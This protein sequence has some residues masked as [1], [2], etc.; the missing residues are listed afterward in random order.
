MRRRTWA[1]FIA[2]GF[3]VLGLVYGQMP[4]RQYPAIEYYDF[5]VP[6]DYAEKT[7]W[8]F[9]RLIYPGVDPH[10]GL[11]PLNYMRW[12]MDYPRSDRHFSEA[13]RRLT[14]VHTR[15]VEQPISLDDGDDVYNWPFLYAVEVG[16]WDLTDDQVKKM[17]DYLLR[18]GFFMCDDFHG[19]LEWYNFMAQHGPCVSR[20]PSGRDRRQRSDFSYHLRPRQP[21]SGA[22]R[23]VPGNQ[24][25]LGVGRI[26]AALARHL[27]RARAG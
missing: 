24:P 7:E 6:H 12:T 8:A 23:A 18:G 16:Y 15:S 4:W 3:S 22:G 14:R 1:L 25:D 26:R 10:R 13:L 20:P 5:P 17:R 2:A 21:L 9:G 19:T 11:R 27:R